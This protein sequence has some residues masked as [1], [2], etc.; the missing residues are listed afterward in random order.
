[1]KYLLKRIAVR[2][3]PSAIIDRPKA[4]FTVP[5][6]RWVSKDLRDLVADQLAPRVLRSQGFFDPAKIWAMLDDHWTGRRDYARSIWALVMFGMWWDRYIATQP[7]SV[8][9]GW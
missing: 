8:S 1:L 5:I 2:I 7:V 4:G 3:L 9:A 6:A